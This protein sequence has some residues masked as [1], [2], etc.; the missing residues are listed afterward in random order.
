MTLHQRHTSN[1]VKEKVLCEGCQSL[2]YKP[3][4]ILSQLADEILNHTLDFSRVL[5]GR[6]VTHSR[7]GFE[8]ARR[9]LRQ[10]GINTNIDR[11]GKV[12]LALD[13]HSWYCDLG[14][15]TCHSS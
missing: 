4:L 13:D 7:E 12:F 8:G 6:E 1:L 14:I 15:I 11:A 2:K 5:G 10:H 3:T 9:Q